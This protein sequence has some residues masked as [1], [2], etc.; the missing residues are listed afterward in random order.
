MVEIL[1]YA[2]GVMYSPGPANLL[3]LNAGL[4][5][6]VPL[7]FSAGVGLAMLIL[8][9]L[10]G[11]TGAWLIAPP[12]QGVISLLG[13][14]YILYLAYKVARASITINDAAQAGDNR[15]NFH[16]GL[17]LQLLNPKAFIAILPIV[18]VQFPAEGIE[19]PAISVWSFALA[20]LAF[21]APSVYMLMGRY[22]GQYIARPAYFRGINLGMAVL[23]VYVAGDIAYN[24]AYRV[25]V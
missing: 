11:Y 19:G 9:L 4:N 10:F 2:L 21:G 22:M 8:F 24:H 12:Y 7:S 17:I 20:A 15:L 6:R 13:A 1:A 18:T 3:S 25:W 23:L 5:G 14:G 16:A